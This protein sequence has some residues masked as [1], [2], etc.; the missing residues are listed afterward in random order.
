[1]VVLKE[2]IEG[3][4]PFKNFYCIVHE[5]ECCRCGWAWGHHGSDH[6]LDFEEDVSD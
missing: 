6:Y 3:E 1:V 5:E 2:I 4:K